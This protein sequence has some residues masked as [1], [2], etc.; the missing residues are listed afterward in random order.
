MTK[1]KK[2]QRTNDQKIFDFL[3][4][5]TSKNLISINCESNKYCLK[6]DD[7]TIETIDKGFVDLE[8]GVH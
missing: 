7:E 6:F 4:K 5:L 3:Q 8:S 2:D 1:I